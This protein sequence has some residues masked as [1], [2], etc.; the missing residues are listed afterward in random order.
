M[1][2]FQR[3]IFLVCWL[4]DYHLICLQ[5]RSD[6]SIQFSERQFRAAIPENYRWYSA[7]VE[8][9]GCALHQCKHEMDSGLRNQLTLK[10]RMLPTHF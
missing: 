2:Y 3:C 9:A 8:G 7:S 4:I 6:A 10:L 1:L 5:T